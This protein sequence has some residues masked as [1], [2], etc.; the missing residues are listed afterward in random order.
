MLVSDC[1]RWPWRFGAVTRP[2]CV[3][4]RLSVADYSGSRLSVGTAPRR[5]TIQLGGARGPSGRHRVRIRAMRSRR[6][7]LDTPRFP[8][9]AR[10]SRDRAVQARIDLSYIYHIGYRRIWERTLGP[11]G[12]ESSCGAV[13]IRR[14]GR[15]RRPRPGSSTGMVHDHPWVRDPRGQRYARRRSLGDRWT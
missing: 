15:A 8:N 6:P 7:S 2:G 12:H 3:S 10:D 13:H 9:P 14:Y 1:T 11:D 4:P 5:R